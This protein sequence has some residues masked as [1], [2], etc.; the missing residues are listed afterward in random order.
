VLSDEGPSDQR[1]ARGRN[2]IAEFN[3]GMSNRQ[4]HAAALMARRLVR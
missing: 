3:E 2:L 4:I 1:I